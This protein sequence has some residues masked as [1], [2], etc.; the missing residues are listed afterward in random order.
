M[1]NLGITSKQSPEFSPGFN[2]EPQEKKISPEAGDF[3]DASRE[4]SDVGYQER[5]AAPPPAAA[6]QLPAADDNYRRIEAVL[7]EGLADIYFQMAPADQRVFKVRGEATARKIAILVSRPKVKIKKI[8]DLI[9]DWLKTISGV[10]KFF[11]EQT[12]KIKADKIISNIDKNRL[13]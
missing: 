13:V 9:K 3:L 8:I 5:V 10:N 6:A 2:I 4:R 1:P 11:L 12:A 7:E